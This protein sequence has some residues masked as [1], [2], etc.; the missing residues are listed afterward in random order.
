MFSLNGK[1]VL[2]TGATGAIGAAISRAFY[3]QGAEVIISGT[4]RE[5]LEKLKSDLGDRC[6]VYPC[7][8]SVS[9]EVDQMIPNIESTFGGVDILINNAGITRDGLAMRMKDQDFEDVMTVNLEVPFKLMRACLKGMMKNRW[10]RMI[11]I[12]SIV[13]VTGNPGQANYCASKAGIIGLS[14]SLAAEVASRNITVNC[15]APG[16]IASD[17]T[18]VLPEAQQEKLKATIPMGRMGEAD[19][20]ASAAIFLASNEAGYVTGQT[21]HVNG[22]MAM[23]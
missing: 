5:I 12:S 17:M 10:G 9:Q 18:R 14:K 7:N 4:R 13:G 21:I 19:D 3:A 20:I 16:F 11:N 6:H 8:L 23:I 22:G 15:I 1:R 2:I